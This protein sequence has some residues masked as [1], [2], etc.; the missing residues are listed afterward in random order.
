MKKPDF[1]TKLKFSKL[2]EKTV[3][4]KKLSYIDAVVD[5]CEENNIDPLDVK[6]FLSKIVKEKIEAEARSLHFLPQNN[7]LP[8]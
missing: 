2:V 6:K 3:L 1:L 7:T 4:S 5:I 8:V